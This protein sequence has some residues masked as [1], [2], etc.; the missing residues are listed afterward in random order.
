MTQ[1]IVALT[2]ASTT[3][4]VEGSNEKEWLENAKKA[5]VDQLVA[6]KFPHI[7]YSINDADVL[8]FENVFPGMIVETTQSGDKGIVTAVNKKTIHVKLKIRGEV[9][10]TPQA[11]K[12]S[13][14]TFEEVR[15]RRESY[16]KDTW[17]EGD[18]GYIKTTNGIREVV[19]GKASG[20]KAKLFV[21]NENRSISL[22]ENE[23]NKS[24][25]EEKEEIK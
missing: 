2:L 16:M 21:I 17:T 5:L 11:F 4:T 13:T 10:G 6:G 24:L 25:K 9:S 14:A 1:K 8:T 7:T 20:T 15:L 22:T 12:R 3:F 23:M 18:T 19:V